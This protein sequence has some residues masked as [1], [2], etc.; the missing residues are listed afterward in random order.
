MLFRSVLNHKAQTPEVTKRGVGAIPPTS[1]VKQSRKAPSPIKGE[2]FPKPEA[3]KNL[4]D[5]FNAAQTHFKMS[6]DQTLKKLGYSTQT[7]I[8]NPGEEWQRLV[9]LKTEAI[10]GNERQER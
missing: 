1:P 9:A 10:E 7:A 6:K 4:G 2:D 8:A 5:L 3:I